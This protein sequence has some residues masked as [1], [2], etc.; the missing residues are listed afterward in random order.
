[1]KAGPDPMSFAS[2]LSVE[3]ALLDP[4]VVRLL[5]AQ[6]PPT[7]E[8]SGLDVPKL[9]EEH[10]NVSHAVRCDL[11]SIERGLVGVECY[12][13]GR[14]EGRGNRPLVDQHHSV[15]PQVHLGDPVK[16]VGENVAV[17]LGNDDLEGRPF[18]PSEGEADFPGE[19]VKV[20]GLH[21]G[22]HERSPHIRNTRFPTLSKTSA[23]TLRKREPDVSSC[24]TEPSVE[25]SVE[26]QRTSEPGE[27][28]SGGLLSDDRLPKAL[29][30]QR[31]I[32]VHERQDRMR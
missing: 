21:G 24:E 28:A 25:M 26:G 3:K 20:K 13:P 14:G 9:G 11:D 6:E 22:S 10:P 5:T 23:V 30:D 12:D 8:V 31:S 16:R 15:P 29:V 18:A 1:M 32:V 4:A 27:R 17:I 19:R 7:G 2:P